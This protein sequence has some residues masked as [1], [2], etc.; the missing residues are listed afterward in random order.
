MIRDPFFRHPARVSEV[1][2]TA[3]VPA[4]GRPRAECREAANFT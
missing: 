2:R 3:H 4:L 1:A